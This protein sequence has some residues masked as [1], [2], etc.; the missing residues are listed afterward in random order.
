MLKCFC[1]VMNDDSG[2]AAFEYGL[3]AVMIAVVAVPAVSAVGLSLE[4]LLK[5]V[6]AVLSSTAG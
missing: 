5:A 2:T 1:R 6:S 3:I 4:Q